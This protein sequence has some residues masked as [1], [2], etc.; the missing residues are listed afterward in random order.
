M[1]CHPP[2]N[3]ITA[4]IYSSWRPSNQFY[5]ILLASHHG[6]STH[7][8]CLHVWTFIKT[9]IVKEVFYSYSTFCMSF[10]G[11]YYCLNMIM[12]TLSTFLA[13]IVI[14]LYFRGPRTNRVPYWVKRVRQLIIISHSLSSLIQNLYCSLLLQ[15]VRLSMTCVG[16]SR[17]SNRLVSGKACSGFIGASYH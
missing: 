3:L 15:V 16:G 17:K 1:L 4:C 6:C 14:H 10:T 2:F 12:I 13:V 9:T 7:M 8:Q 11:A 5:V